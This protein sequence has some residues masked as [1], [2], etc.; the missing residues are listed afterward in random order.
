MNIPSKSVASFSLST[1]HALLHNYDTPYFRNIEAI[2]IIIDPSLTVHRINKLK[3]MLKHR[4]FLYPSPIRLK[5]IQAHPPNLHHTRPS[6]ITL[7]LVASADI[8][9]TTTLEST[10]GS[11]LRPRLAALGETDQRGPHFQE[12]LMRRMN[13]E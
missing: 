11:S 6:L 9:Q 12:F 5:P 7:R 4:Q 3:E 10:R 13:E 2:I 1:L 8:N